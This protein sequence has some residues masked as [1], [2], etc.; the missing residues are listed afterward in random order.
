MENQKPKDSEALLSNLNFPDL[1][2][3]IQNHITENPHNTPSHDMQITATI[4]EPVDNSTSHAS[5]GSNSTHAS[6]NP[7]PK[8]RDWTTDELRKAAEAWDW[9]R[10]E[11]IRR[12]KLSTLS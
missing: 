12:Q 3:N 5:D 8:K 10:K 11:N 4:K 1:H 9:L 6:R 2:L 7:R